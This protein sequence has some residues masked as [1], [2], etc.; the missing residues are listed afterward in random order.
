MELQSGGPR[1]DK[2][3]KRGPFGPLFKKIPKSLS[4]LER[5]LG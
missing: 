5:D 3:K 4:T 2:A 1:S